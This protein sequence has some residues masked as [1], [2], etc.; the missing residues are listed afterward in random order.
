[1]LTAPSWRP[2]E[3]FDPVTG[4]IIKVVRQTETKDDFVALAV[5]GG[6]IGLVEREQ[7]RSLFHVSRSFLLLNPLTSNALT[8]QWSAPV[9]RKHVSIR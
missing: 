2:W 6:S 4:Q 1:M 7:V 3:T 8:G 5:T 9:D